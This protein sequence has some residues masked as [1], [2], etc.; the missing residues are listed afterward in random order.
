M[1]TGDHNV[2]RAGLQGLRL[3]VASHPGGGSH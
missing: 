1:D 3:H 2:A